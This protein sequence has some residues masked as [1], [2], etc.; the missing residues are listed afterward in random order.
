[1]VAGAVVVVVVD[2]VEASGVAGGVALA[3]GVAA[4]VAEASGVAAGAAAGAGV[5]SVVVVSVVFFVQPAKAV[6]ASATAAIAAIGVFKDIGSSPIRDVQPTTTGQVCSITFL[7]DERCRPLR[8][9]GCATAPF[10]P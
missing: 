5:V 9:G 2:E 10:K 1:L 4:G 6:T 8:M 3:S 7:A